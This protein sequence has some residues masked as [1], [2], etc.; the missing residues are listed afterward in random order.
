MQAPALFGENRTKQGDWP[1]PCDFRGKEKGAEL[2]S[3]NSNETQ[4]DQQKQKQQ[5]QKSK[6]QKQQQ[7]QQ[8]QF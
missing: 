4:Q 5:N 2:M 6:Q 8:Y 3:Y 7:N 1:T